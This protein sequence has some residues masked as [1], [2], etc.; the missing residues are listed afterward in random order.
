MSLRSIPF[1]ALLLGGAFGFGFAAPALAQDSDTS[2][3][4]V[5]VQAPYYH[6]EGGRLNGD[7]GITTL[8]RAVSYS[9]LD[10][11]TRGG[12]RE[13]RQ[14]IR[15]TAREVCEQLSDQGPGAQAMGNCYRVAVKDAL[16]RADGAIHSAR[17]S[18]YY[19]ARYRHED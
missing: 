12:A 16:V 13:L 3:E 19:Q 6:E 2:A 11:G 18:D 9:D 4:T 5:I 7:P 1:R 10:L 14:R 17:N 8:S 15:D